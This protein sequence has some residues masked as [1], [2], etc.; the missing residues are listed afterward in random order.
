[1]QHDLA[2]LGFLTE[3]S[4]IRADPGADHQDVWFGG[5]S[6]AET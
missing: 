4:D 6:F 2:A 1:M 5:L 3:P